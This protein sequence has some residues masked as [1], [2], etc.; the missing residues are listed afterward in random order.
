[1]AQIFNS[2]QVLGTSSY[3]PRLALYRHQGIAV[4]CGALDNYCQE[5]TSADFHTWCRS[6]E[7]WLCLNAVS[8]VNATCY[9]R[10]MCTRP[11]KCPGCEVPQGRVEGF[12]AIRSPELH[13][14]ACI[15]TIQTS[16]VLD[17][18]FHCS[19][20]SRRVSEGIFHKK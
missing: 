8:D 3:N 18:L 12:V 15:A 11:P 10:L 19:A 5:I 13:E 14:Q 2:I 16:C 4:G 7:D 17:R 1:M 20:V 9:V 6:V